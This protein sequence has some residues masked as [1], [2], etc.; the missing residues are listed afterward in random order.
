VA[1]A[2][3]VAREGARGPLLSLLA[4]VALVL[5]IACANVSS[6]LLARGV[7]R[8]Q[9]LSVR[10]AL[11]AS[12]ARLLR[13]L[14]TE[15]LVLAGIGGALGVALAHGGVRATRVLGAAHL[16][17]WNPVQLD[18][19]VLAFALATIAFVS[20]LS[21]L[22]PGL[23]SIAELGRE[24]VRAGRPGAAG[25]RTARLTHAVVV[26]ETALCIVLLV[27]AGLLVR[28][29]V[30]VLEQD[31]GFRPDGLVSASIFLPDKRYPEDAQQ[32][33][34]FEQLLER[35]R[36]LPGVE[37]VGATTTLPM[38]PVGV[39]HDMPFGIEGT[40][41]LTTDPPPE[42]D[43]RIASDDYFRTMGIPVLAGRSFLPTDD[44][45]GRRVAIISRATAER[46][47]SGQ[48]PV[49]RTLYWGS[50][51]KNAT[52]IV[53]IVGEVRHRGLETSPRPEMYLPFRQ[54][55]YGSLVVVTRA[56]GDAEALGRLVAQQVMA[57]DPAL[58]VSDVSTMQGLLSASLAGR[59]LIL[60][61]LGAFAAYALVLAATGVYGVVSFTTA[62]RTHEFGVRVALGARARDLQMLV[63]R[64]TLARVA[65][66]AVLGV[67]AAL[68]AAVLLR[69]WLFQVG[70]A[71]PV[72]LV[73]VVGV[74]GSVALGCSLPP[75]RR[76]TRVDPTVALRGE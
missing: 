51:R 8:R 45:R 43:F 27:G 62:R 46:Y 41:S 33:R 4:A 22:A 54:V 10:S 52:E 65:A 48:D 1:P 3:E 35:V 9:E 6:L 68:A 40:A 31:P 66:G 60:A 63:L 74:L 72:T 57:L 23:T 59:R 24:S 47:L 14:L 20:V 38:N 61:I 36:R 69:T 53:G 58:A 55:S 44:A 5:L 67:P 39:D 16:P 34:F 37:A 18:G 29:L 17:P 73:A 26:V 50:S 7:A 25:A 12:R 19:G 28:S 42:A 56:S 11:G 21:G 71:D 32:I 70:P 30:R 2:V 15:A 13:Y 49:G 76:A 64:D 75:A